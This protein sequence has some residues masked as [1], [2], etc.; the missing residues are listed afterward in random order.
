MSPMASDLVDEG[1]PQRDQSSRPPAGR[2]LSPKLLAYLMGPAA[3][4]AILILM[5]LGYL[6]REPAWAWLGVFIAI[7]L[8]NLIVDRLY[9]VRQTSFTLNLRVMSQIAAVTVVIFLSGWGPVLWGAYAFVALETIAVV[10]SD[11]W[12]LVTAWCFVGLSVGEL[13]IW[14][15]WMPS[16]L[17]LPQ[18][19]ALTVMGAFVLLFVIRMAGA[20]ME[21]KE[22]AEFAVR[23]SEDRFRSL[24]QN[25]S[26]VTLIIGGDGVFQFLSPAV[27]E[28]LGYRPEE[29]IGTRAT[30]L[31]HEDDRD[32]V[33]YRLGPEFQH[34]S[35]VDGGTAS[36][37]FAMR[38]KT[39]VTRYVEA[40]VSNQ[41]DRPS[42]AGFVANVRN[43]T[44]RKKFEHLLSH[45]ALHDPLTGLANRQLILDRA[46][47]MLVRAR[48][49]GE[50][51][52]ALFI[53]LDNFK[54]AND[55]LGHEAGDHLLQAVA[56][57]LVGLLRVSDTVG[58]LGGDEFVILA[59]G[60]SLAA[61]PQAIA[62]R[63]RK[64]LRPPFFVEG[65]KD[66]PI[67]VKASIGIA[68]GD[69]DS[70]QD[71]LRDADIALYRAKGQGRNQ[72]V[73]FEATMQVAANDRLALRNELELA[74]T[75]GE[76][77]LLY[78]PIF[79]LDTMRI[80]GV[81]ALLRW[82]HPVEGTILPDRF[83]PVLEEGGDIVKVGR[84]V[85]N[86]AC[87]Q[88]S[89]WR[90]DGHDVSMSI[91]ASMRQLESDT[92]VQDVRSALET[93]DLPP[94]L[95]TIEITETMLMKDV[96]ATAVRL[97]LL[98]EIGVNIAIDDFGTGYSSM[99]YLRQFP[100]DILKIDR[101]FIAEMN[102]SLDGA[103]LVH[104]LIELGRALGLVTLAEGIEEAIQMEGLRTERCDHGQG[105]LFSRPI[106][107]SEI[108]MML[109]DAERDSI[110][111]ASVFDAPSR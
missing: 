55:S 26:D 36:L 44:E 84:W 51:V 19:I 88:L 96:E 61:G 46:E 53:D 63:V 80:L 30:A 111:R 28:L 74:F 58:R 92:F 9:A 78:Q 42:V 11:T 86:H 99:A 87:E 16:E 15:G 89:R 1:G 17:S 45:R 108:E 33:E 64:V 12:R 70:A 6:D 110:Q 79:E 71:L 95:L 38:T 109:A 29:L 5:H 10:G 48:R 65:F 34:A 7:P 106:P 76:Y 103:A 59:E 91:N 62:E 50:P 85:L 66:V 32:R 8:A 98:K 69:R 77:F 54:D 3:F 57:R 101:S 83:I 39:G 52:A 94:H 40:V 72:A 18:S 105:F 27:E 24:I 82:N 67:S 31:V 73:E 102:G 23:M 68:A 56:N 107:G 25:S 21:Q 22:S 41:L 43:I 47:Q 60:M 97:S 4:V 81:E 75:R 20:T 35:T 13:C 93:R 100:V 37:E 2:R 49:S 104:T 90:T 14:Q